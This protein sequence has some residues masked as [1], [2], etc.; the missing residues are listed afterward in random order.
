MYAVL[1][2]IV[3]CWAFGDNPSPG[4]IEAL[5]YEIKLTIIRH[6]SRFGYSGLSDHLDQVHQARRAASFGDCQGQG[7]SG[8]A[9]GLS[10][11]VDRRNI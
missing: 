4:D 9:A 6:L 8:Y 5:A 3:I 10:A 2:I 1:T 7:F 11:F